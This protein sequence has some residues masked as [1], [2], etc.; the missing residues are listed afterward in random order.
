MGILEAETAAAAAAFVV[1]FM[2]HTTKGKS[3]GQIVFGQSMILP[4]NHTAE[5]RYIRQ[6]KQAQIDKS[7]VWENTNRTDHDYRV[8]DKVMTQTK[9]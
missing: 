4:I 8:G 9:S 1:H 2:Y 6:L 5:W 3:I 7:V